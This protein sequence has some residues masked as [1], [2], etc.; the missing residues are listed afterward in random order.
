MSE[1]SRRT[2]LADNSMVVEV[3]GPRTEG[4]TTLVSVALLNGMCVTVAVCGVGK[5]RKIVAPTYTV[6]RMSYQNQSY[7]T[8][9]VVLPYFSFRRPSDM[10]AFTAAVIAG[11]DKL[12][13]PSP[14]GSL[15]AMFETGNTSAKD[16]E[17]KDA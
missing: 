16:E 7:Y 1:R 14:G 9:P 4:G 5:E 10:A 12:E 17:K 11:L 2:P 3:F 8:K 15:D 13:R 6:Q